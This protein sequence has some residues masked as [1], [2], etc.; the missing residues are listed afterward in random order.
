MS[1]LFLSR[2]DPGDRRREKQSYFPL[3]QGI[4]ATR[5]SLYISS[6]PLINYDP[7]KLPA[8]LA[9]GVEVLHAIAP[10]DLRRE[11][12]RRRLDLPV[13][14]GAELRR[15]THDPLILLL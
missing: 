15:V 2:R 12:I 9:G 7:A 14:A 1:V 13:E 3:R 11:Q 5:R 6:D 4:R 8:G 10:A